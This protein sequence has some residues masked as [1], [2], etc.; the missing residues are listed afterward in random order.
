MGGVTENKKSDWDPK[1]AKL[2]MY[3]FIAIILIGVTFHYSHFFLTFFVLIGYFYFAFYYDKLIS[4]L[5]NNVEVTSGLFNKLKNKIIKIFTV[6]QFYFS[7]YNYFLIFIGFFFSIVREAYLVT[8]YLTLLLGL[9]YSEK[10]NWPINF[11]QKIKTFKEDSITIQHHRKEDFKL[12]TA[13]LH[14]SWLTLLTTF[15]LSPILHGPGIPEI[16]YYINGSIWFLCFEAVILVNLTLDIYIIL[17]AN[18]PV[19]DKLLQL[20]TRCVGAGCAAGAVH[21]PATEQ[22]FVDPNEISNR[23]RTTVMNKPAITTSDDAEIHRAFQRLNIE[24]EKYTSIRK[25]DQ[26][27]FGPSMRFVDLKKANHIAKQHKNTL[28]NMGTERVKVALGL[29]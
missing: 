10:L 11:S 16:V 2:K 14:I 25:H 4:P 15:L 29:V 1:Q 6:L 9:N 26:T 23:F 24:P 12:I 17:F 5:D 13:W 28:I 3:K 8:F 27:R 22:G 20:C 19:S 7:K 21:Q 18:M